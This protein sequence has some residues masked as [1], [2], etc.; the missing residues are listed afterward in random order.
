[1]RRY[2]QR[3]FTLVVLSS[4]LAVTAG[5]CAS[6][7]AAEAPAKTAEAAPAPAAGA[8]GESP[9]AVAA[10]MTAVLAMPHRVE[11]NRNR[12]KYRHPS[13]RCSSSGC[14]RA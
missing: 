13:R 7:R 4:G 9:E 2:I 8:A 11:A 5:A 1:M 6:Q 14:A 12:D 10:K 3:H